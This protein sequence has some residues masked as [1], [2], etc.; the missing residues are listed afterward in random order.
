MK[1]RTAVAV[2]AGVW[3]VAATAMEVQM[4]YRGGLILNGNIEIASGKGFGDGLLLIV[5]GTLAHN[6]MELISELQQGLKRNGLSS[7]A[8]NLSLGISDRHGVYDCAKP[9]RHQHLDALGEIRQWLSW[10]EK[11]GAR[12]VVLLGH[13][14]GANQVAWFVAESQHPMVRAQ[15][16]LA[17]PVWAPKAAAEEYRRRHQ[18]PLEPLLHRAFTME[19]EGRS[20]DWLHQVG[21]LYCKDATVTAESF[22]GYYREDARFDTAAMAL[23][24]QIP[25]LAIVGTQDTIAPGFP[26]RLPERVRPASLRL[27]AVEG[28]DHFFRDLHLD[29]V[30]DAVLGFVGWE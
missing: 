3:G 27:H 17:P 8:I 13:S 5:H 19:G 6:G 28:A 10:L 21:F 22:L 26:E 16:L 11:Q 18:V 12:Q 15:V 30:I 4:P 2:L 9:H 14:R 29:E 20:G 23:R 7:L 1:L 25:T 24:A